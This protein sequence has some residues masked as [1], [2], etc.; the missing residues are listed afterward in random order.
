MRLR[1]VNVYEAAGFPFALL[2]YTQ[3]TKAVAS[4]ASGMRPVF[5]LTLETLNG[6]NIQN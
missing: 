4:A 2:S 1:L 5:S 6:Q 3:M